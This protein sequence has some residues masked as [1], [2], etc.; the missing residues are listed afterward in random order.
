MAEHRVTLVWEKG[1]AAFTY[2]EYS[3]NHT[4]SFKDGRQSLVASAASAYKGD[5]HL[6][7]PEDLLVASLS[8]CHM[9]SF[10]ALAAK[11]K[12]TVTSYQDDAVGFLEN[13]HGKL[14]MTR[15]VLRPQVMCNADLAIVAEI[16]ELAHQACFIANSVRTK[17]LV[18]P[19]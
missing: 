7:D 1:T 8:S 16:H 4:L 5:P 11:R 19:R 13:D 18:E 6:A 2:N 9:L 12:V 17:V 14:W 10:L 3:R 15:V